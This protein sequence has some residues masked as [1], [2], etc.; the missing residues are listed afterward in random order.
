MARIISV[1]YDDTLL[2]TREWML[3][4]AGHS[5][6]SAEGFHDAREACER[7]KYDLFVLGHSI[8]ENDK[9][10]LIEC[11]R[12]ASPNGKV[13]ALTR[14]GERRLKQVDAYI[15]PGDPEELVRLVK[16]LSE[17]EADRRSGLRR[18]K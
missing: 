17:P 11:F 14:A 15:S 12:R 1:S 10:K 6:I 9:M 3:T 2:R 18:I 8:P 16:I 5:V 4:A 13:I 7:P